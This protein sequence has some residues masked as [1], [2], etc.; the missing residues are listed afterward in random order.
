[1]TV[2]ELR[3]SR[4]SPKPQ[5]WT[6]THWLTRCV[7]LVRTNKW[8]MHLKLKLK[9]RKSNS[10]VNRN[11]NRTCKIWG[12][13]SKV[14]YRKGSRYSVINHWKICNLIINWIGKSPRPATPPSLP[15]QTPTA[16]ATTAR[17]EQTTVFSP[18]KIL[19]L[20]IKWTIM[21]VFKK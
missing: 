5:T 2:A 7:W 20:M 10:Q 13:K 21:A 4:Q 15:P 19:D 11:Y 16:S 14:L 12:I 6:P 18:N 1:M 9:S 3:E 8:K 17:S